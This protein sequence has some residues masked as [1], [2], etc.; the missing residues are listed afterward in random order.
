MKDP[1]S[2][3]YHAVTA[4]D[5]TEL[6]VERSRTRPRPD[7]GA[8]GVCRMTLSPSDLDRLEALAREATPGKRRD[9]GEQGDPGYSVGIRLVDGPT[10]IAISDGG[11]DLTTADALFLAACDP[12]TILALVSMA[13]R[14]P[15]S[16][17]GVVGEAVSAGASLGAMV[18]NPA[19]GELRA[20]WER[21]KFIPGVMVPPSL[22][23]AILRVLGDVQGADP[24]ALVTGV[25][26]T[27][28]LVPEQ[29]PGLVISVNG[30]RYIREDEVQR[31]FRAVAREVGP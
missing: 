17:P 9:C 20:A 18:G 19:L 14:A 25:V 1:R 24:I 16:A 4:N 21:A 28:I 3:C 10:L 31:S 11:P 13:R 5:A 22:A 23:W 2:G 7:R 30:K 8:L 27:T 29:E 6:D 12:G 26:E 15:R